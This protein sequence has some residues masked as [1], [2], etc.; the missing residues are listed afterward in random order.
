GPAIGAGRHVI[1]ALSSSSTGGP[2]EEVGQ[3]TINFSGFEPFIDD[4]PGT[5]TVFGTDADNAIDYRQGSTPNR[6]LVSVDEH[7][8][9]EF[10]NKTSL[11]IDAR[12]GRDHINLNNP[13]VPA[14]F[15]QINVVG[16]NAN[17]DSLNVNGTSGSDTISVTLDGANSGSA[18][19]NSLP[20]TFDLVESISING[21]R[22]G[23]SL[24]VIAPGSPSVIEFTPGTSDDSGQ[25]RV[26][27]RVPLE[28][29]QLGSGVVTITDPDPGFA[30]LIHNG[31]ATDDVFQVPS[32]AFFGIGSPGIDPPPIPPSIGLND[33]IP[34]ITQG[35][36]NYV[37]R[38]L[39]GNDSF[40]ISDGLGLNVQVEGDGPDDNDLLAFITDA[41]VNL[42]LQLSWFSVPGL[43]FPFSGIENLQIHSNGLNIAGTNLD[44]RFEFAPLS[45]LEG[46]VHLE[47]YGTDIE[48]RVEGPVTLD[49]L[50]GADV[51]KV[52]GTPDE[53]MIVI[54]DIG[55]SKVTVSERLPAFH[56][57]FEAVNVDG[58]EGA[59]L[60]RVRMSNK[61]SMPIFVVGG[62]PISH[63]EPLA[64]TSGCG[65]DFYPDPQSLPSHADK[66]E[67]EW[68]NLGGSPGFGV[69]FTQYDG[70]ENDSG[71]YV[72]GSGPALSYDEVEDTEFFTTELELNLTIK[73]FG[74]SGRLSA[75]P[76]APSTTAL[77]QGGKSTRL[78]GLTSLSIES[79][80]DVSL[81][82]VQNF[83]IPI[84][85]T[86]AGNTVEVTS[87]DAIQWEPTGLDSGVLSQFDEAT[88]GTA[89]PITLS[90]VSLLS[91][92][93]GDLKVRSAGQFEVFRNAVGIE[94]KLGVTFHN[95]QLSLKGT[96]EEDSI[97]FKGGPDL[98]AHF[99]ASSEPGG[100]TV[101]FNPNVEFMSIEEF[102]RLENFSSVNVSG[103]SGQP[104]TVALSVGNAEITGLGYSVITDS[105]HLTL[106]GD[107][108]GELTVRPGTG[109]HN[110]VVQG[111]AAI[112][113]DR[114]LF[115]DSGQQGL[116]S[117]FGG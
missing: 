18:L 22:G 1:T 48:F 35:I 108:T 56:Q 113:R 28:F 87:A 84:T 19:V 26:D 27:A 20:V 62:T 61:L 112:G 17:D 71:S 97:D 63:T 116:P 66:L 7:E 75:A 24:E 82:Q 74:G 16:G 79:S 103:L 90:G 95:A 41:A 58:R 106:A 11:T 60:I 44:D 76:I 83:N 88:G 80:G 69:D 107:G 102:V 115:L 2:P 64:Q 49:G 111:S 12:A 25:I 13:T 81:D 109:N 34:I 67:V 6:G 53:D 3:L 43:T 36:V 40:G 104:L 105:E 51:L 59:D 110:I 32:F 85:V 73:N 50:A 52:V 14:G 39:E 93:G 100:G 86:G 23:D 30:R 46:Q 10:E 47:G 54:N 5:L 55:T 99:A 45:T 42:D 114:L 70:P 38:G 78:T 89:N 91:Y 15:Q 96:G 31:Y 77:C 33:R 98:D 9:I 65:I 57:G 101:S 68:I 37:L 8:T 117:S 94:G 21:Q 4:L 92:E 29:E 72:F